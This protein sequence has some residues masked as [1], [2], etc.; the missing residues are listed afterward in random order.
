MPRVCL[1]A[2]AWTEGTRL[3]LAKKKRSWYRHKTVLLL[4]F[5]FCFLH[6]TRLFCWYSSSCVGA[7]HRFFLRGGSIGLCAWAKQWVFY[8]HSK[9]AF[10]WAQHRSLCGRSTNFVRAQHRSLR[11]YSSLFLYGRSKCFFCIDTA[12]GFLY[13]R[14]TAFLC[15]MF[16]YGRNIGL[17]M[18]GCGT[19]VSMCAGTPGFVHVPHNLGSAVL[20]CG[21]R[22]ND[23]YAQAPKDRQRD[24]SAGPGTR[25]VS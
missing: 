17:S 16:L 14:S 9:W 12:N 6:T 7:Q 2:G 5:L 19:T 15:G 4:P 21:G 8:G 18:C 11:G 25:S 13:G 1:H 24:K 23:L 10:V 20:V 3:P 22:S